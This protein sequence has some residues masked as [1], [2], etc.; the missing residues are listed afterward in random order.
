MGCKKNLGKTVID[1]L[2]LAFE[3]RESYRT[4]LKN[5]TSIELWGNVA[6]V[7]LSPCYQYKHNFRVLIDKDEVANMY[8]TDEVNNDAEDKDNTSY[9]YV[10]ISNHVLYDAEY[11]K[12]ILELLEQ[13]G[14]SFSHFTYMELA[15]DFTY[16]VVK[17]LNILMRTDGIMTMING[18]AV[19]DKKELIDNLIEIRSRSLSRSYNAELVLRSQKG[20]LRLKAY[21]KAR[22][23]QDVG[24]SWAGGDYKNYILDYYGSP[25]TLHRLEVSANSVKLRSVLGCSQSLEI[26]FNAEILD[27]LYKFCISRMIRFSLSSTSDNG[28]I[29]ARDQIDFDWILSGMGGDINKL[30]CYARK[31]KANKF[32]YIKLD[33]VKNE[34][35]FYREESCN[36]CDDWKSNEFDY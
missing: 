5:V 6:L 18:R 9:V 20:D 26:L 7:R 36:W 27:E 25:R 22:E 21:N 3:L 17:R 24:S 32:K 10:R 33:D 19:R 12:R 1:G 29:R 2:K 31:N 13:S 14:L 8:F 15:R 30:S 16:N 4:R 23:I 34:Q 11:L 28:H 35:Q